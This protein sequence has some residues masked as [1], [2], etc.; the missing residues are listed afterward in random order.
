MKTSLNWLKEYVEVPWDARTL[1]EKL[2][3]AGLEVEGIEEVGSIP[4]GVVVG[5]IVSR[6]PHPDSDH[7]SVCMVKLSDDAEP[8]QI[9][10]GA[11]N[12]DAGQ[13]VPCAT[14]GTVFGDF[15][16]KKAKLRGVESNGMLCSERELGL[17][18]DHEGLMILPGDAPLGKPMAELVET[19]VVIDW[20]T[21]PNRPDWLSHIGI[22]R[23]IAAQT[24][25]KL[26]HPET[27]ID[28]DESKSV[29]DFASVE[30]RD[31]EL[32]PR[33]IA[34]VF[35]GVKVG[36]S[37]DWL[38]KR[39]KAVGL[40]SINNVVDITN[41][42]MLEYGN[43]LHAFDLRTL[44]GHKIIVRRADEGEEIVTLDG[45][46]AKLNSENL[47]I[48]DAEKGVALAGVM[49]GENSMIKDDTTTVLL[50]AATFDRSNVR[51][52][53]RNLSISTDSS[54]LFERGVSPETTAY[55]SARAA[56]LL[57]SLCG[58]KQVSGVIDCYGKPF[59][60]HALRCE[61]SR[62]NS[63][64]GLS[65]SASE[66]A[67]SFHRRGIEVT[68]VSDEA[69]EVLT[70]EWRF[71]LLHEH[72]L[73]EEVAQMQGLDK[74]PE[75]PVSAKVAGNIKDDKFIPLEETR[76]QLQSLG[77]DEM[78]NYT[79]F[80][81]PQCLLGSGLT[82]EQIIRVSNPISND[83]AYMRPTMLPGVLQVVNHNV[84]R[85]EHDL[86]LFELGRVFLKEGD[87]LKEAMQLAIVMTGHRH[88]GRYGAE[89]AERLDFY[90]MKGVL[91]SFLDLRRLTKYDWV[92]SEHPAFKRGTC[93][94]WIVREKPVI[95][96][97]QVADEL[98]KGIRLRN[99][100]FVALVDFDALQLQ[101][102]AAV[103]YKPMPQFPGTARDISF[104]AP[105]G[106]TNQQV[107]DTIKGMK[108]PLVEKIDL[109]DIFENEKVLGKGK[110]SLAY[111][112][113]YRHAERTLTDDEVNKVQEKIREELASKLG[114]EL[115]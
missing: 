45:T 71:D 98:V 60:R 102:P 35:T 59:E 24:G 38:V 62:C 111:S 49:G 106:L 11:P 55:A 51:L 92:A 75:A 76:S 81:L 7:M 19:D 93:A 115:R 79:M 103:S 73:W 95:T 112:I 67:D 26:T 108:L 101:R 27:P 66:M 10:C 72:D 12:C 8:I 74:I 114:I 29:E 87:E 57:C 58:A 56:S 39:L 94:A 44:A 68:S 9:V 80:S 53:S 64:L 16:I 82:E 109:F 2:T 96:F 33:Y 32:C 65:L 30:V 36:P 107:I 89:E 91:E 22:A 48:A 77:L 110:R 21:T 4:A 84:S 43:P 14:I 20:E 70:P 15:K 31:S 63:I 47:L 3:G 37:P 40:R 88:L 52:T 69:I 100:L 86:R 78:L 54:Y 25:G 46:K 18:E 61:V 5:E 42:V 17:S 90:D 1:A 34:R 6:E 113:T 50:E 85:N 83:L 13:R 41:F 105:S 28:V 99:P 97:G 23:E 104:V